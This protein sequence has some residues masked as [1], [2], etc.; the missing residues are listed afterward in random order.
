MPRA[1]VTRLL[2]AG[3]ASAAL[4]A[5]LAAPSSASAVS[6]FSSCADIRLAQPTAPDGEYEIT[7]FDKTANVWCADMATTPVEYLTLP[8]TG[9][10]YNF[11]Q[12]T[13]VVQV[14]THYTRVRLN[15]PS[16]AG[17]PFSVNPTDTRF[18]TSNGAPQRTWGYTGSCFNAP[19]SANLDLTGTPF[20][21]STD[22]FVRSGWGSTTLSSDTQ[23]IDV[24]GGGDCGGVYAANPFPLTWLHSAPSVTTSPTDQTA[25]SGA[26]ATFTASGTGTPTPTVSWQS[27][28][29]G[30]TWTD[31]AG[32]TS[33]TLTVQD[34]TYTLDGT[35]YRALVTNA[36][37]TAATAPA[38][39]TVTPL[40]PGL[41]DP[42]DTTVTSGGDATFSV[43]ITGDP[44]P[45]V[46]WQR[47]TDGST[48]SDVA[49]ATATTLVLAG[50]TTAQHGDAFRA[51]VTSPGGTATSG[52]AT[53]SVD[54]TAP[55]LTAAPV[56]QSV[57][58]GDDAVFSAAATGDPAPAY[59]WQTSADNVVWTDVV[60]A[61]TGT[62]TLT[63]VTAAQNGLWVRVY[64]SNAGGAVASDGVRLAVTSPAVAPPAGQGRGALAVTGGDPFPLLGLAGALLAAGAVS[65]VL[66]RRRAA[67]G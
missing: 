24:F 2:T 6:E 56:T 49:G 55:V 26:D 12:D 10:A 51:V 11:S 9:G 61:T 34:V 37:G 40:A 27:S 16:T 23:V 44:T 38:E 67:V 33:G 42:A 8:R 28:A 18:A 45:A 19:N 65:L 36:Q 4:L 29:D 17:A 60:G 48:W 15:L 54:P 63:D 62:L 1:V 13:F 50:V 41:S 32:A 57:E 47:S 52:A 53:L 30:T 21:M 22:N 43:T 14:T 46:Q 39:L 31:V 64:V 66:A 20:G 5:P 25:T 7:A 58:A 59:Q 35:L 3:L